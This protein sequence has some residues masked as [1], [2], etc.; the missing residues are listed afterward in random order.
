MPEQHLLDFARIDVG[1]AADD[2]VLGSILEREVAVG[3]ERAEI[4]G[5]QPAVAQRGG[6]RLRI[7]PIARHHHVP[8]TENFSRLSGW[9]RAVVAIR[10]DH[11]DTSKRPAGGGE[12]RLPTRMGALADVLLGEGGNGHRAFALAIN[13]GQPRSETIECVQRILD[14]HRRAAP[15]D[16]SNIGRVALAARLNEPL[17]H[18]RCREH[19]GTGPSIEEAKDLGGFEGAGFGDDVDT[20]PRNV[21]HDV[22]AR[23][24]AHG[25]RMHDGI[26]R[27]DRIDL[28]GVGMAHDRQHAMGEHRALGPAGRS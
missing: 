14:I 21:G 8:A 9:Q 17:D 3:I 1:A 2:D 24:V 19:R 6:G 15:D 20:E 23:A 4:A 10:H 25:C 26:A 13:L 28:R 27:R 5:M 18:G 11:L 22:E 12:P 7:L 16:R